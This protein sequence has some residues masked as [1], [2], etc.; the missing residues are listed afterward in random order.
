MQQ[1][2]IE[3]SHAGKQERLY[4]EYVEKYGEDNAKFLMEQQ[5]GWTA[6]Y[7]RAAFINMGIGDVEE[8]RRF[9]KQLA[10]G[11]GWDYVEL[12]GDMSLVDRL[13]GG[14]WEGDDFLVVPPGHTILES[15][16]ALILKA[17][18]EAQGEMP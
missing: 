9:T 17:E 2:F 13:A 18:A 6:N 11:K 16:D 8:Y 12:E 5:A 10:K 15:F 14:D 3:E 7:N 1:G 4:Q